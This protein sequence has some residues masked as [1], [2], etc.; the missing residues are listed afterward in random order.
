[1]A[2]P[3]LVCQTAAGASLLFQ[4]RA[5]TCAVGRAPLGGAGG[6]FIDRTTDPVE[7]SLQ[8]G[9]ALVDLQSLSGVP[10]WLAAFNGST[11]RWGQHVATST[12]TLDLRCGH[13]AEDTPGGG[14]CPEQM[15]Q[16]CHITPPAPCTGACVHAHRVGGLGLW[17]RGW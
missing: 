15:T 7:G 5:G 17:S 10:G 6:L 13:G 1:V 3:R 9:S 8:V 14:P 2:V 12:S 4:P 11:A 16:V